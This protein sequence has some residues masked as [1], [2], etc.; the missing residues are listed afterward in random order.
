MAPEKENQATPIQEMKPRRVT[1]APAAPGGRGLAAASALGASGIDADSA[2]P[3]QELVKK[4]THEPLCGPFLHDSSVDFR[5]DRP[6]REGP[7]F[8]SNDDGCQAPF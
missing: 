7:S 4:F 2:N 6:C 5:N 3:R 8:Y 1:S